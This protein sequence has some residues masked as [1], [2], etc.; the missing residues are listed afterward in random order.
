[1][2][3]SHFDINET[4]DPSLESWVNSA[5]DPASDFPIQNLPFA[6]ALERDGDEVFVGAVMRIGDMFVDLN[7]LGASGEF[8]L[9]ED[10]WSF[11]TL[12]NI[13][14]DG[15]RERIRRAVQKLLLKDNA[16]L[17]DHPERDSFV[18][19]ADDAEIVAPVCGE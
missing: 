1:M 10:D 5:N 7:A 3:S 15:S 6:M 8:G 11:F 17:R 2:A 18:R 4:H 16:E 14:E 12:D 9:E 13:A 19:P